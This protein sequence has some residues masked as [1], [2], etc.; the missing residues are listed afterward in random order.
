MFSNFF[1][2]VL[3]PPAVHFHAGR[4]GS[5]QWPPFHQPPVRSAQARPGPR[6]HATSRGGYRASTFGARDLKLTRE[7]RRAKMRTPRPGE[8][9]RVGARRA[10]AGP[11]GARAGKPGRDERARGSAGAPGPGGQG[12]RRGRGEEGRGGEAGRWAN[13]GAAASGVRAPALPALP[14]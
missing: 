11:R 8:L 2:A 13:Q 10:G 9:G 3:K 5:F 4:P 1:S 6:P 12:P 14:F 7:P